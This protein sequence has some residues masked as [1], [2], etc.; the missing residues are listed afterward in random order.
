MKPL[1]AKGARVIPSM[2]VQGMVPGRVYTV[3]DHRMEN[4]VFG[5]KLLYQLD[6]CL[7]VNNLPEWV[8][9]VINNPPLVM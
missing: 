7:W 5:P 6:G 1:I 8:K 9:T 4:T 2:A 3:T